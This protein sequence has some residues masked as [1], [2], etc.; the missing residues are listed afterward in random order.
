MLDMW[1][2]YD[3][4][5]DVPDA[6]VARRWTIGPR[7]ETATGETIAHENLAAIRVELAQ[8]GLFRIPRHTA[9][10]PTILEVW[11]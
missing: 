6:F 2:V 9:D 4:P 3:H 8:R 7:G 11:L 1:V 10:D 5:R